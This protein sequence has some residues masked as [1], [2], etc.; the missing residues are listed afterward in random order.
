MIT[1][2]ISAPEAIYTTDRAN[3]LASELSSNDDDDW[4]YSVELIEA[5]PGHARIVIT[6]EDGEFV[7]NYG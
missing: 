1:A 2:I 5:N 4:S 6:D 3:K 7:A